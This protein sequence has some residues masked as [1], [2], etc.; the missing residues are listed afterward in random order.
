[1]LNVKSIFSKIRIAPEFYPKIYTVIKSG[2][3]KN[4]FYCDF[5][6]AIS[7]AIIS[8]PLGLA[9]AIASGCSPERGLYTSIIAG[10]LISL[11]GGSRHQ[12]SGPTAAFVVVVYNI[13]QKFGYEGLAVA[14]IMAG[15]MVIGFGLLKLGTI[16]KYLPFPI[17]SGFTN[18]IGILLLISQIKDLFGLQ[19]DKVPSDFFGKIQCF[20]EN[21]MSFDYHTVALST[22]TIAL[23]FGLKKWKPKWPTFLI[24]FIFSICLTYLL[25]LKIATIYSAFGEIS[26]NIPTPSCPHF[27]WHLIVKL[28]PSAFTIAFLAGIESLLSCVIADSLSGTRH[29]SNC[30]LVA[31]GI[32]NIA[33]VLCGGMPAT[34][35]LAR[36]ATNVRSGGKTPVAGILQ[37]L[38]VFFMMLFFAP[39]VK[40]VPLSCL[41]SIL[42]VISLNMID[43]E[44][45][46]Y[47]LRATK[48][49]KTVFL[50]TLF[51]TVF[52]D[53]TMA[54][55]IGALLAM[56]F[57][58][59]RMIEV[60]ED[61]V[62]KH[63]KGCIHSDSVPYE[64]GLQN[65]SNEIEMIHIAGPFFFGIASKVSDLL[66]QLSESPKVIILDMKD[67]PFID[68]SGV[69]VLKN[70]VNQVNKKGVK[71]ILAA[72]DEK[73]KKILLQMSDK[74]NVY[75]EMIHDHEKAI[76]R[77]Y[78]L[79]DESRQENSHY[80]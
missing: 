33:S 11:L 4:L 29:R 1:M 23:I 12:I 79:R 6:A 43:K 40:W 61:K 37:A 68:A 80:S 77:A 75:G 22:L 24:A 51:L 2:Y 44:N 67:V 60:T 17:T 50:V 8:L 57:F 69:F 73:V 38:I 70:F 46:N 66:S 49:D 26:F 52:I 53:I 21:F 41:A 27:S 76:E 36:T 71:I 78:K 3:N 55:E 56:L 45:I 18:G 31:Q 47:M 35:A 42:I 54:I 5:Q 25:D 63:D 15:V 64:H 65:I 13:M 34:G 32:G 62:Y 28:F 72:V 58:T 10:F 7:V 59:R 74:K 30:E 9:L 19:I 39:Y 16:I 14:T 48:S 20:Y